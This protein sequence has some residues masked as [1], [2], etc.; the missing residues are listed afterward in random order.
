MERNKHERKNHVD[1][2]VLD[3]VNYFVPSLP[4]IHVGMYCEFY[5]EGKWNPMII[6]DLEDIE[7]VF[8]G[9]DRGRIQVPLLNDTTLQGEGWVLDGEKYVKNNFSLTYVE[10]RLEVFYKEN[11]IFAGKCKGL[12][13]FR[14]ICILLK[15]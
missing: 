11:R 9:I 14:S 1:P 12:N 2:H 5:H 10:E 8:K 13:T 7:R 15:V 6:N 4:E 3:T